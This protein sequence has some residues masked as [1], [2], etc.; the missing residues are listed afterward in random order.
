MTCCEKEGD[1]EAGLLYVF[2]YYSVIY[3]EGLSGAILSYTWRDL[4]ATN[5]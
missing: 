3:M 4:A 1:H 5:F 2:K